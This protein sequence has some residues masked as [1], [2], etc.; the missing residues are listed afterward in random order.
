[1]KTLGHRPMQVATKFRDLTSFPRDGLNRITS[2]RALDVQICSCNSRY[3]RHFS[4]ERQAV[5]VDPRR[6]CG[7][8]GGIAGDTGI[9]AAI[10]FCH[11]TYIKMADDIILKRDM[12][13]NHESSE[14]KKIVTLQRLIEKERSK[15]KNIFLNNL[16]GVRGYR[17]S[18]KKPRELRWRMS[19]CH[20]FERYTWSWLQSLLRKPVYELWFRF[21]GKERI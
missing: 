19:H 1:M 6:M 10:L 3:F 8:P 7:F 18:V 11:S 13:A 4:D 15:I 2:D 12:L 9:L 17:K 5:Y 14:K 20:A 16:P 21:Y